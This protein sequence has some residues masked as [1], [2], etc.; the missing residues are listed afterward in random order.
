MVFAF[1]IQFCGKATGNEC[2]Q[3]HKT[4]GVNVAVEWHGAHCYIMFCELWGAV[5]Q[6]CK[7]RYFG[8]NVTD[9]VLYIIGCTFLAFRLNL[10]ALVHTSRRGQCNHAL[11]QKLVFFSSSLVTCQNPLTRQLS[12]S[13]RHQLPGCITSNL[14]IANTCFFQDMWGQPKIL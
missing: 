3:L 4:G 14:V 11:K 12:S 7:L 1:Y 10:V 6:K 5:F 9:G 2:Y 13:I 8:L